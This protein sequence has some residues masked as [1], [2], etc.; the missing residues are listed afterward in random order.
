[1]GKLIGTASYVDKLTVLMQT[2]CR[3]FC[4]SLALLAGILTAS[5]QDQGDGPLTTRTNPAFGDATVPLQEFLRDRH[6][7]TSK[8]QHFCVVGYQ[9]STDS[10]AWIHWVEGEQL[11]L[12]RG[13]TNPQGAKS[14]I[15]RSRRIIHLKK[16]VVP[17][18]ADVKGSTYLVT[19]A[20]VDHILADCEARGE[21]YKIAETKK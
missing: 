13:A 1:M 18:E 2:L 12:W 4:L 10:R 5:A 15:A 3:R 8:S 17:T 14:A 21:K 6:I 19:R 11:I 7:H 20:W 16:D 9:G